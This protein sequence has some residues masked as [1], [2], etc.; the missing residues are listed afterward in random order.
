MSH[1][2]LPPLPYDPTTLPRETARHYIPA[3]D[4]ELQAM[5]GALGLSQL[6]E[7]FAHIPAPARMIDPP[8]LPEELGYADLYQHVVAQSQKNRLPDMTFLEDGLP[9]Y[10]VP[11]L[12]PFVAGLR[13]LMTAYT[14]YQPERSQGTLMTQWLYQCCLAMLTGF[15]AINASQYDR[16][17]ALVEA[18]YTAARLSRQGRTHFLL[19]GSLWPQDLEVVH[20]LLIGT[21]LTYEIVPIDPERGTVPLAVLEPQAVAQA[22][23]LAGIAFPQVNSLGCLEDVDG[24]TELAHRLGARAIVVTDPMLLATGGL[25]APGTFGAE[26]EGADILVGEAQHL[27]IPPHYG[28]PGLGVFGMRYNA[29]HQQDIRQAPGRFVGDAQDEAGR[30]AKV[31]VLSTREQHIRRHKATSNICTNQGFVATLA[32]TAILARGEEGMRKACIQARANAL[33][34][35]R[36]LL[37]VPGVSLAFPKTPFWNAFVLALPCSSASLMETARQRRMHLGVDVSS[38]IPGSGGNHLLL[39]FSDLQEPEHLERLGALF[40]EAIG[41][42]RTEAAV[43]LPEVPAAF[44][45]RESVGLPAWDYEQLRA[46]FTSLSEQN[47]SPDRTCYPLGSC[48]MKYNPYINEVAAALPGFAHL[49]PEAPLADAQGTLEV[50]Y[51]IQEYFKAI[52]GL[53]AVTTQPVAGAQGELVGLKMFQAYHRSR[54]DMQRD[55]VLIPHSAHGT[56]PATATMAGFETVQRGAEI[57]SGV[58]EINA[59]PNGQIAMDHLRQLL[60]RYRGRIAGIMITNP[61]TSGV[62]ERHFADIAALIHAEG[63]LVYMD[64]ANMNAIAGWVNLSALGVDAVHNNNHKTWTIPHGGGGPGDAIVAVSERLAPFLPGVQVVRS[65]HEYA[66]QHPPQ[67]IGS[68][69]RHFGNVGHKIRAYT[70]LRALGREGVRRMSAVAVLAARYLHHRLKPHFPTLPQETPDSPRMHEF[71]ITLPEATFETLEAAGIGRARA[72]GPFGKLFLDFG[73]HAPT[74]AFPEAQGLMI[75]PTESYTKAELDRFADSI[76]IMLH[77]VHEQPT[78]LHTVPHFTPVDRIDDVSA[79]KHVVVSARLTTLP[80]VLPN[81]IAPDQLAQMPLEAIAEAIRTA[82]A[83]KLQ[84]PR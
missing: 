2:T 53:P 39:S 21:R 13:E 70:Y 36:E 29:A 67:S 57:L 12:V 1:T 6:D 64:G 82:S 16:A 19:L 37:R 20:T 56:N 68:V 3:T 14:P 78:I 38:R 25:K 79:N 43:S 27:A 32:A 48:T 41:T 80:Q 62:F 84:R 34:A 63:G 5:L 69:H 58:V 51:N 66:L 72:I 4:E 31:M 9:H 24:L 35:A 71:I 44:L 8:D 76:I 45:R 59:G 65:G 28:G 18:L 55:I 22:D 26:G 54:G 46:F 50:L 83:A 11:D 49:H 40:A 61:N 17:T 42:P 15:E 52:T 74:V 30:P 60:D 47:I 77:L 75:E 10:R 7:L 23:G 81:R 33:T 73:Y